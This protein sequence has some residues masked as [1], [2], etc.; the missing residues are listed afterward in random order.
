LVPGSLPR[1]GGRV[2][3]GPP[4]R[5]VGTAGGIVV[6]ALGVTGGAGG[7]A[8]W[9]GGGAGGRSRPGGGARGGGGGSRAG[10]GGGR[11][12]GGGGGRAGAGGRLGGPR[13]GRDFRGPRRDRLFGVAGR[14]RGFFG[15]L[16]DGLGRRGVRQSLVQCGSG[17]GAVRGATG[18]GCSAVSVRGAAA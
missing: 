4:V 16:G 12:G 1:E 9:G 6:G 2:R 11:A 18:A 8:G 17:A 13:R 7:T 14:G 5:I 3:T 10:G 15:L